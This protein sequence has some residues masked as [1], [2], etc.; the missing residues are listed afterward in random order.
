MNLTEWTLNYVEHKDAF[1]KKLKEHKVNGDVIEFVFSDR[2]HHYIISEKLEVGLLE[3]VKKY[4]WKTI[5]CLNTKENLTVL[6]N[7]W[8]KFA[9]IEKLYILFVSEKGKWIICP[10]IHNSISDPES[11]EQGLNSLFNAAE[12]KYVDVGK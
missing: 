7:N 12:G 6:I 3:K 2:K 9:A 11:L 4:D 5:V 1:L 8:K 10:K